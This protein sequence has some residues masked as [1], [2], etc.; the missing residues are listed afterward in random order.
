MDITQ[1]LTQTH[2]HTRTNS[3]SHT[4]THTRTH[5][6]NF[7]HI[8]A[9]SKSPLSFLQHSNTQRHWSTL[10]VKGTKQSLWIIL[11]TPTACQGLWGWVVSLKYTALLP[12]TI[13]SCPV[14]LSPVLSC[15]LL[16]NHALFYPIPQSTVLLL[17]SPLQVNGDHRIGFYAFKD[18]NAGDELTFDYGMLFKGHAMSSGKR[19]RGSVRVCVCMREREWWR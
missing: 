10:S 6:H 18:I 17:H 19:L 5:A 9:T 4:L 3:Y 2:S 12:C 11:Q 14:L 1:T 13:L 7:T 8:R 15:L 16:S